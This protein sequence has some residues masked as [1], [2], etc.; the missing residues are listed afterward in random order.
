MLPAENWYALRSGMRRGLSI[1]MDTAQ[2]DRLYSRGEEINRETFHLV[3]TRKEGLPI[4]L[5]LNYMDAHFPYLP[6]APFDRLFP[7]KDRRMVQQDLEEIDQLVVRGQPLPEADRIHMLSQ[8]DGGIASIDARIGELMDRLKQEGLYDNSFVVITSDHGEAFDEKHLVL[9]GNS[10]YQ[11]LVHVALLIKF[12]HN[13]HIGIVNEPAS[14]IDVAPTMLSALGYP[15]PP[16]VQ[17][18]DLLAP[19]PPGPRTLFTESFP[20][21]VLQAP[22]CQNCMQRA[23]IEWPYKLVTSNKGKREMYDLSSD[24]GE[25]SNVFAAQNPKSQ[26]LGSEI[27]AWLKAMPAQAKQNVKLDGEAL[28]RLKS[29]G[30]VQ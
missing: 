30:Y 12:P 14:L 20:C 8:Y 1:F 2:F 13:A 10:V 15:I 7:G 29:L 28:Q 5:F 22:E 11:N 27:S 6:P 16:T 25:T 3:S 19:A 23:V 18:R 21:P 9:H 4:F 24:E 26:Q 17:G